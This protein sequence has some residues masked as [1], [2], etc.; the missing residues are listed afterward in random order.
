MKAY[1]PIELTRE[2]MV[3]ALAQY[4]RQACP[5]AMLSLLSEALNTSADACSDTRDAAWSRTVA[6][7][8][9][10]DSGAARADEDAIY[11]GADA[12]DEHADEYTFAAP[13]D[14]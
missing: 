4:A 10:A 9:R 7:A 14:K 11:L 8:L 6:T 5:S 12:G 13:E 3:S 1:L 2:V